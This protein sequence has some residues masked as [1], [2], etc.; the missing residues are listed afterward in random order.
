MSLLRKLACTIIEIYQIT[1]LAT[2]GPG[3]VTGLVL[4]CVVLSA[5][6]ANIYISTLL[7]DWNKHFFDALQKIDIDEVIHQTGIFLLL[8]AISASLYLGGDYVRK[9]VLIR[10]RR[11]LN[12]MVLDAW[13]GNKAYWHLQPGMVKDGIDNPDQRIAEDCRQFIER[14]LDH[15]IDLVT[16][17]VGLVTYLTILWS[18]ASFTLRF[19]LQS[20][21]FAIP[22]YLVWLAFLYVFVS[23]LATHWLGAP[24]RRLLFTQQQREADY[25]FSLTRIRNWTDSIA[26]AGGEDA[27][28]KTLDSH[29]D[30][31]VSNWRKVIKRE[32]ILG[33]FRRPYFQ[34]VLKVPLLFALPIYLAGSVTFGGLMQVSSAFSRVV[35]SLSWFIFDYPKL[36]DWVATTNRLTGLLDRSRSITKA[37]RNIQ[38]EE[39]ERASLTIKNLRLNTPDG[40]PLGLPSE[41]TI[42]KGERIWLTGAS[43]CGK[44]T[45]LKALAGLWDFG[46]GTIT[47]PRNWSPFFVAQDPYLPLGGLAKAAC[48]PQEPDHRAIARLE[49][50]LAQVGLD[51]RM[52]DLDGSSMEIVGGLSGGEKQR[53]AFLRLLIAR[54]DWVFLDEATSALD[55]QAETELISLLVRDLPD[56]TIVF[57]AHRPP[58]QRK[59]WRQLDIGAMPAEA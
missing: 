24:L 37:R 11:R 57:V 46:E 52:D 53:L 58:P 13:L 39:S 9:L 49:S 8:T 31:I 34:T 36:A 3:R 19:S 45:L 40:I 51:H 1:R 30:N 25:R 54:P 38:L 16:R 23:S 33:C 27:E 4:F 5:N 42:N 44:T 22:Y 29:F 17:L 12:D 18:L 56:T 14:L 2:G 7:I 41:L 15:T 10:W 35:N 47:R 50:G 55:C 43:G 48:Y 20:F 28:R 21:D 32:F 6:L 59:L 26:M